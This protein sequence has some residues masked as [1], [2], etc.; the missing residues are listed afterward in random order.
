MPIEA[1]RYCVHCVDEKGELQPF[2]DRL[3]RM[4]RWMLRQEAGLDRVAAERRVL[5]HMR[6]MPAWRDHPRV[7]G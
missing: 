6:A 3:E 1:G 4:V 5:E 2:E 7:R